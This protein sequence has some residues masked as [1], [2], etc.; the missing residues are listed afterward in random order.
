MNK[1][2]SFKDWLLDILYPRHIKCIFCGN[3]L[4]ENE[5][6][7]TCEN[8][9]DKLPFIINACPKCGNHMTDGEMGVC[10]ECKT[11]NYEFEQAVSV[12][13]Y[14]GQVVKAIHKFKYNSCKPYFEPLGEYLCETLAGWG[15]EPDL[16]TFVPMSNKRQ[17]QR[18]FNQAELLAKFVANCFDLP[19]AGVVE[20]VKENSNQANLDYRTRQENIKDCFAVKKAYRQILQNLTVLLIDDI[21]TTGA[22]C[23]EIS[24]ILKLAGAKKIYILTIAHTSL[25]KEF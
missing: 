9:V 2:R 8:C 5:D 10:F 22:T 4:N 11:K 7:E 18:G 3:E 13:E 20:K 12:F 15:I 24:K 23:N 6:K 17:K 14:S 21:F 25:D 16:I 1:R 19:S